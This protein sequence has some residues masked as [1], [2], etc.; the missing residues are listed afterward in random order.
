MRYKEEKR[1]KSNSY[2]AFSSTFVP[3]AEARSLPKNVSNASEATIL[4]TTK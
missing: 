4:S 2:V 3:V 1:V